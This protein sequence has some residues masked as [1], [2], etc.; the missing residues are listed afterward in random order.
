MQ[1]NLRVLKK[2]LEKKIKKLILKKNTKNTKSLTQ[3]KLLK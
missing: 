2:K 1:Y 3:R